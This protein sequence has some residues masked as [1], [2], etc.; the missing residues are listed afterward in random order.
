MEKNDRDYST[1]YRFSPW[2]MGF[3]IIAQLRTR[4]VYLSLVGMAIPLTV[5][6]VYLAVIAEKKSEVFYNLNQAGVNRTFTD[7]LIPLSEY[8]SHYGISWFG[9]TCFL[10][11]VF[12]TF[13]KLCSDHFLGNKVKDTILWQH[14][15]KTLV[16]RGILAT[17][18]LCVLT[19]MLTVLTMTVFS[20]F[21]QLLFLTAMALCCAIPYL[22]VVEGQGPWKAIV[23]SLTLRYA[24]PIPGIKW[25]IF[26]QLSSALLFLVALMIFFAMLKHYIVNLDLALGIPRSIWAMSSPWPPLSWT[27]ILAHFVYSFLVGLLLAAFAVITTTFFMIIRQTRSM[28]DLL[29]AQDL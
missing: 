15:L 18:I 28:E 25:S 26:F 23:N 9:I 16:P 14:S 4:L 1:S 2:K 21:G 13:V 12:F 19:V 24:P 17:L 7:H 27:Y 22:L 11:L 10:L 29:D 8:A 3:D 20:I 5:F 6:E